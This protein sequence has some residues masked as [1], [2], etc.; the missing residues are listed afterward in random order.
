[1]GGRPHKLSAKKAETAQKLYDSGEMSIDEIC[2]S[3]GIGRTT[4]YRYIAP[5]NRKSTGGDLL[6]I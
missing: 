5:K 4:L 2:S 6:N 3:M 1:M